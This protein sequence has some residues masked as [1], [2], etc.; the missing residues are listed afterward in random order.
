MSISPSLSSARQLYVGTRKYYQLKSAKYLILLGIISVIVGSCSAT[1]AEP[2]ATARPTVPSDVERYLKSIE[3]NVVQITAAIA[4]FDEQMSRVWPVRSALFDA[5]DDSM[6]SQQIITSMGAIVQT[7]PPSRFEQEHQILQ[8]SSK[9]IVESARELEQSLEARDLTRTSVAVT[10]FRVRYQRMLIALSPQL[11][12]AL[13]IADALETL[14]EVR[15]GAP[16]T[17]DADVERLYKEFRVEFLPRITVFIPAMS[18]L[19]RFDTL[20][21]LNREVEVAIQEAVKKF[22]ALSPP[23]ERADDHKVFLT[24]LEEIGKTAAAITIAGTER[25]DDKIQQLFDQSGEVTDVAAAALSCEYNEL[26]LHGFH[27]GCPS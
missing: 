5:A 20:A 22:G 12:G 17:Y 26:L 16:G 11:C 18:E 15:A 9:A 23:Q 6:V 14:C 19:E 4:R 8:D 1:A 27:T 10:N 24:Y 21:A 13:A 25:D 3:N 7:V 2:T